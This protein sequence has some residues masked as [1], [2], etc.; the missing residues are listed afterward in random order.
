[1][2]VVREADALELIEAENRRRQAERRGVARLEGIVVLP[3]MTPKPVPPPGYFRDDDERPPAR[4]PSAREVATERLLALL[5]A[6]RA[7]KPQPKEG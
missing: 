1:M 5:R 4:V 6:K 3:P 7:G 2:K